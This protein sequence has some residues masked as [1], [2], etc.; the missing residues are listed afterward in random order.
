MRS[1]AAVVAFVLSLITT[2]AQGHEFWIDP[3][4]F[5]VPAGAPIRADLRVGETFEGGAQILNPLR[6]RRHD[7][8]TGEGLLPGE[9]RLGDRP[10][11][12]QAVPEG[13]AVIL[14]ATVDSKLT[15][16]AFED[17]EAFVTHKAAGW[18][19]EAHGARDL[20]PS[21]FAE[22]YSRYAKSLVAIGDGAG[23]DRAFGLET[24]FVAL[25]NPY[26]DDVSQGLP[27]EVLY[28]GAPRAGEQVEV[29]EKAPDGAVAVSTITTDGDG[30]ALIAVRPGHRYML[31]SVVLREPSA[32]VAEATGAVWESLWANLTF[33]VPE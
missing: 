30:R 31:D 17:F 26:S 25:K 22:A 14:V 2:T 32:E 18:T 3:E 4:R 33:A 20:P 7:V 21:G 1:L 10:A 9:G 27:V 13:L 16:S 11:I 15:Y 8:A 12:V 24:E 23:S 29:F 5:I 19:V 6:L 28:G